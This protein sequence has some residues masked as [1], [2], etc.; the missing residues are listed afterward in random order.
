M[1]S[2]C[3]R[4]MCSQRGEGHDLFCGE[5][6]EQRAGCVCSRLATGRGRHTARLLQFS[7]ASPSAASET[8]SCTERSAVELLRQPDN[9]FAEEP[10]PCALCPQEVCYE[11]QA[12]P[13]AAGLSVAHS[14]DN[15]PVLPVRCL[16][17]FTIFA[18]VGGAHSP[19]HPVGLEELTKGE[20]YS[21]ASVGLAQADKVQAVVLTAVSLYT[22]LSSTCLSLVYAN[23]EGSAPIALALFPA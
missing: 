2:M 5:A 1:G 19:E 21:C 3:V 23:P 9:S 18:T 11:E 15:E 12:L 4:H 8:A 7:D 22:C 13:E 17:K 20:E 6:H 14:D 16:D 10:S